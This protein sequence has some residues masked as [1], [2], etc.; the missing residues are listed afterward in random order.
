MYKQV[1]DLIKTNNPRAIVV[2]ISEYDY[3]TNKYGVEKQKK[4]AD[5]WGCPLYGVI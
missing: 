1:E 5:I 3:N 2:Q 4:F